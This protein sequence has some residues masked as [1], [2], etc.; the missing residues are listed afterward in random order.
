MASRGIIL[1]KD[2]AK[3]LFYIFGGMQVVITLDKLLSCEC[4]SENK[5]IK[6][7]KR[8][9]INA[10]LRYDIFAR[11]KFTCKRCGD[12]PVNN[13]DCVLQID[14]IRPFSK[15]GGNNKGNL[16]TLCRQCNVGKSNRYLQ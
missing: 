5:P 9:A 12:S 7:R 4:E 8:K 16:Q 14:H 11:D 1:F 10:R 2:I 3:S 15:G 13:P 6:K